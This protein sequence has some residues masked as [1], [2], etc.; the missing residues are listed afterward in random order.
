MNTR[1][2]IEHK[3]AHFERLSN[4]KLAS[5]T[6]LGCYPIFY[7]TAKGNYLCATCAEQS[8]GSDVDD[9]VVASDIHWEGEPIT[10]D[11]CGIEIESAYGPVSSEGGV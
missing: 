3:Q 1:G 7:L 4:G 10:C 11:D 9:P 2:L 5:H 6:S 8:I